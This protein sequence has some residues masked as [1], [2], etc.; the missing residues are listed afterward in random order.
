MT[1]KKSRIFCGDA[2]IILKTFERNS[3]DGMITSPPYNMGKNPRHR[4]ENH[5][6]VS[7]YDSYVDAMSDKEYISFVVDIF[8][9]LDSLIKEKGI[10][11]YNMG[12]STKMA[13]LP[14]RVIAA[15]LDKTNWSMGDVIYWQKKTTMPFQTSP[16]KASPLV[17]PIYIFCR[18]GDERDFIANK[19]V[20]KINSST[21][22]KFYG[23]VVNHFIAPNGIS[24]SLNHATFSVEMVEELLD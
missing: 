24:T 8:N 15:I 12:S 6:D 13:S 3:I 2:Q 9:I 7:L 17:E 1:E 5:A 22:Q 21:G 18:K 4:A 23:R 19:K 14:F 10:I 11:C 20:T 16:N